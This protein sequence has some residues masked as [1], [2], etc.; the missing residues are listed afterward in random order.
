MLL[1]LFLGIFLSFAPVYGGPAVKAIF[2]AK[3]TSCHGGASPIKF[4]L[5]NVPELVAKGVVQGGADSVLYKSLNRPT[6]W[7]PLGGEPLPIAEKETI[8]N[9]LNAGYPPFE[10][11]TPPTQVVTYG[12]EVECMVKD[13]L[14]QPSHVHEYL[15]YLPFSRYHNEGAQQNMD[16][17]IEAANKFLNS[18]SMSP[19][20]ENV[21]PVECGGAKSAI[22]RFN[23]EDYNLT[24]RDWDNVIVRGKYPYFI[25]YFDKEDFG[26]YEDKLFQLTD[27]V[28]GGECQTLPFARGDWFVATASKA[29]IYY[30]LLFKGVKVETVHDLEKYLGVDTYEQLFVTEEARAAIFRRS[31]VTNYNR[32]LHTYQLPFWIGGVKYDSLYYKSFDTLGDKAAEKRNLFAFP[33]TGLAYSWYSTLTQKFQD[34]KERIGVFDANEILWQNANGTISSWL[35]DGKERRIDEA[36][37]EIAYHKA[38]SHPYIGTKPGAIVAGTSCYG[39]HSGMNVFHD[40]AKSYIVASTDFTN[41]Q[42]NFAK[43]LFYKDQAEIAAHLASTNGT[44]AQAQ[45]VMKAKDVVYVDYEEPIFS[46]SRQ[47]FDD[48]GVCELGAELG[49]DCG[50]MKTE[51]IHAPQLALLLGLGETLNGRVSRV[52]VEVLMPEIAKQ[53]DYGLQVVFKGH[54]DPP[55]PV[56]KFTITNNTNYYQ[57][58]TVIDFTGGNKY[59]KVGLQ[60]NGG[61]RT[62]DHDAAPTVSACLSYT[63]GWCI[64][65]ENKV[66]NKCSSY[67]IVRKNDGYSY[68]QS[69]GARELQRRTEKSK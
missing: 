65:H 49:R 16:R 34:I 29:P 33:F 47:Y 43:K 37:T 23:L 48:I 11:V 2:Q 12:D 52:N 17:A 64:K 31:N 44:Y 61:S 45:K 5:L 60:K 50:T 39:C 53:L 55:P 18:I 19:H 38:N 56:C 51:L 42:V 15:R 10:P 54:V 14:S 46:T 58:L 41:A 8:L 27:C 32:L 20:I 13:A 59:L 24:P 4:D 6:K 1:T 69:L 66:L 36:L 9:W 30:D 63:N 21:H 62:W 3:C 25:L 57:E 68:F 26:F 22:V 7:M 35:S 28:K 40:E 67:G